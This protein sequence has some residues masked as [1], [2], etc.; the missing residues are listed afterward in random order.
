MV[1]DDFGVAVPSFYKSARE[2]GADYGNSVSIVA[3]S[4]LI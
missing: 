3:D 2:F 4:S 1:A